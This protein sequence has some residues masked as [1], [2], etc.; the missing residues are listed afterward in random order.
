MRATTLNFNGS[1][2]QG[3]EDAGN[4]LYAGSERTMPSW[5][6]A[7]ILRDAYGYTVIDPEEFDSFYAN[8]NRTTGALTVR[9]GDF[10]NSG[11]A[12]SNDEI[13][14]NRDGTDILV[15]VNVS[16]DIPGTRHLPGPGNLPAWTTRFPAADVDSIVV[17]GDDGDDTIRV[18]GLSSGTPVTIN[19][20]AGNDLIDIGNGDFDSNIFFGGYADDAPMSRGRFDIS[21]RESTPMRR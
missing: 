13:I 21:E 12:T 2:W 20:G 10:H 8:L 19:A 14:I 7:H 15:S 18:Y 6:M 1:Q 11:A 16:N 17:E 3:S 9:G 5:T 4:A